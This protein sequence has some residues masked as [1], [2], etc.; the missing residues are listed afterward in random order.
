MDYLYENGQKNTERNYK[1]GKIE[2]QEY[3]WYESGQKYR[4][5]TYN[6]NELISEKKWNE[7]GSIKE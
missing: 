7:D 1:N 2:L 3:Y 5:L 4:E 6:N